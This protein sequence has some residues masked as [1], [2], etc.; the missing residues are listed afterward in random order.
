ML[1]ARD[2]N[3]LCDLDGPW[4]TSAGRVFTTLIERAGSET[5]I[6]PMAS[7][8]PYEEPSLAV[9]LVVFG[10]LFL[11]NVVN[12]VLDSLL[13][14]GLVGQIFVGVLFGTPGSKLLTSPVETTISHLGYLGLIL[15]VY[16]GAV[17][18]HNN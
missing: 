9:I 2:C 4:A 11:L 5:P 7:S 6:N 13:Y 3:S 1:K 8:H 17:Q 16:E 10:F 18:S 14:C 15:L 12:K